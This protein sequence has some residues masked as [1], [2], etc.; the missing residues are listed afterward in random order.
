MFGY[1]Q[2]DGTIIGVGKPNYKNRDRKATL[3]KPWRNIP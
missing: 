3:K 2:R 1:S